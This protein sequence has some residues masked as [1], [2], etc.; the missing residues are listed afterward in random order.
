[1]CLL[2]N[3]I[4]EKGRTVL[5]GNE[6]EWGREGAGREQGKEMAQTIYAHVNK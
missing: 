5:P 3:K 4:G 6:G 2:F 1:L